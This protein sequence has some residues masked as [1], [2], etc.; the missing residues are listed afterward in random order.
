M[1]HTPEEIL[2]KYW[3]YSAFRPSQENVV[4]SVL[5]G[6]D[7]LALLPTG[8]GKSICYQVPALMLRGVTLV[9]SPL[10]ALMQEQV[11]TLKK[12]GV[13]AAHISAG[14]HYTE[15]KNILENTLEGAYSLLY[16]S[17]ER[18]QTDLFNEYLPAMD[19]KLIAVDEA[20][21]V[22]QWGHDFRPDYLKI[23]YL[24]EIF[25]EV[26][27]LALT[28]SATPEVET[29][30]IKQ[31][32]LK[33]AETF[34]QSFERE[35]IFYDVKY[36]ENKANDILTVLQEYYTSP[37][38]YCRSRKATEHVSYQLQQHGIQALA[39]HAGMPMNK[40]KEHQLLWKESN[41]YIMV[42]TTA[43]GMGIDKPDVSAVI[44]YDI[45]EHLEAYYQESGRGGRDGKNAASV[46]LYNNSD[47]KRL[48]EN[49]DVL[50]PPFDYIRQV[51]QS[52]AEYLQIPTG[53]E[54]YRYYDFNLHDFCSRFR[55]KVYPAS[56]ALKLLEQEG[57]WTLT[58][59]VFKP[60]SAQFIADRRE[61]DNITQNYH[62]LGLLIT[63]MLRLYGTLFYHPTTINIKVIAK[64]LKISSSLVEQML[65]KLHDMEVLSLALPREG[66]QLFFHHYR[67]KSNELL[68][69]T[70]R[71]KKLKEQHI[72]RTKSI[73]GYTTNAK[74]CRTRQLLK[75]FGE[76]KVTDCGHCDI[77]K[78]KQTF[79]TSN[80]TL[81][82]IASLLEQHQSMT[83]QSIIAALPS[84]TPEAIMN[85]IRTGIDEGIFTLETNNTLSL[86][87]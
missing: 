67:V 75:Y 80:P 44:H 1:Q 21:C 86:K 16:V 79:Y 47:I 39:Y 30:I 15:T 52:V 20:H 10:I 37:I 54:P 6:N 72:Y 74:T 26:P 58:D 69:N 46:L 84:A 50:F 61:L 66:A 77:C 48:Q 57:L 14:M 78:K 56:R 32:N 70:E 18:L 45:P 17:P 9:I 68:I 55:L 85:I 36:S 65:M 71:I 73:I 82:G 33:N 87:N 64:H 83:L 29:D 23:N 22:S 62:E 3:S 53:A 8:G 76:E 41:S 31:L 38:I 5:K 12:L 63:T 28:A 4:H 60:A 59:S 34:R 7:T 24:K 2:K 25:R 27:I 40:R 49:I 19:I 13:N 11:T 81:K 35:N 43:F 51:Y 42:A